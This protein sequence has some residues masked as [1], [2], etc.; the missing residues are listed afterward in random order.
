MTKA[1][2]N[3][4][5]MAVVLLQYELLHLHSWS[6]AAETAPPCLSAALLVR[7]ENS[8]VLDDVMRVIRFT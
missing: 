1:I 7:H 4:N 5:K 8:Q 3:Y 2:R 6:E